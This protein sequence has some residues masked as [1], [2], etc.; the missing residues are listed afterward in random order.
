MQQGQPRQSLIANVLLSLLSIGCF[1]AVAEALARRYEPP[2]RQHLPENYTFNWQQD[3]GGDFYVLK[4]PSTGW[5]RNEAFN[6]D[7]VRDRE[8]T[9]EKPEGVHRVVCLGDSV[10]L[11]YPGPPDL[12]YP[13]VLERRIEGEG[14]GVEVFNV[15]LMAWSTRQERIAYE[16]IARRY[17]PDQVIL[18]ICLNDV[19]E[20]QNN[21]ARPSPWLTS[22][23]R[24][25]AL[26]RRVVNAEGREID[27][28]QQL[29]VNPSSTAVRAGMARFFEELRL[30]RDEVRKDGVDFAAVLFPYAPQV[31]RDPPPPVAQDEIKA[32]CA[33]EKI[34][35]VDVLPA[36]Q[37][38]GPAGF[39]SDD[40]I[41]PTEA[42]YARTADAVFEAGIVPKA[43]YSVSALEAALAG[44]SPDAPV[45]AALLDSTAVDVRR[46]AA[47]RLGRLG[48]AAAP[49]VPALVRRLEDERESVRMSAAAA[50]ENIGPAAP[51][52]VPALLRALD[53]PRQG[54][55][56]A[57]ANA[58]SWIGV[59]PAEW[60]TLA[61][62]LTQRDEYVRAFAAFSLGEMVHEARPAVPALVGAVQDPDPAVRV[63]VVMALAKIGSGDPE[64]VEALDRALADK[65]WEYRWRAAH[66][67]GRIHPDSGPAVTTLASALSD[68][69]DAKVRREAARA[70]GRIGRGAVP[71]LRTLDS[72]RRDPD[73]EV[74]EVADWALRAAM[75]E[76][77]G[78]PPDTH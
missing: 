64:V 44:R 68:D 32:W 42:G 15:A 1:L 66:A 3:W 65:T 67:L 8:H 62:A 40:A 28:V 58:L 60:K 69:T 14:P 54:V 78:P 51:P 37:P 31:D 55:R 61:A 72:A 6:R 33:R 56:W 73:P 74:R 21:L 48:P 46:Q 77:A 41:H 4:F 43:S 7:G 35:L 26:A 53:D 30:L 76:R 11:G 57:A 63:V 12:A 2:P 49:A 38:L 23:Y 25:S 70:L 9:V 10:T 16:R 5:P 29:F 45:L 71:A 27:S 75:G 39:T 36:L 47:W 50:L 13:R 20:L 17:H 34:P 59:P 18:G 24:R 22:L 52:A 19:Q